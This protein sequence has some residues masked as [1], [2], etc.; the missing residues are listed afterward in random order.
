MCIPTD[1]LA[2]SPNIP[3]CSIYFSQ[4][5]LSS[6]DSVGSAVDQDVIELVNHIW[7]EAT[8]QL[9]HLLT[10]PASSITAEQVSWKTALIMI[11]PT[12]KYVIS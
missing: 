6:I 8:G 11:S 1:V 10:V 5:Q 9:D 2:E 12:G 4:M 3:S 7:K